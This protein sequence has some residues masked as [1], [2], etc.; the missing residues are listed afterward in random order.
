MTVTRLV[1]PIRITRPFEDDDWAAL[2]AAGRAGRGRPAG[3]GRAPD[4]GRRADLRLHRRLRGGRVEHRRL[5]P[6]QAASWPTQ[7]IAP[8][9]ATASAPGGLLHYGQGKWYPGEPL[10]RWALGLYWRA[11]RPAGL[12]RRRPGAGRA[13]P[14]PRRRRPTPTRLIA[15]AGRRG[16]ASTR[17]ASCRRARIPLHW[18]KAEG[19]LPAN[20]DARPTTRSTIAKGRDTLRAGHRRRLSK[21]VGY[22]LPL[23]RAGGAGRGPGWLSEAWR[24]ARP[25]LPGP[26]RLPGR[27]APAARAA[28]RSWSPRTIRTSRRSIPTSRAGRCRRSTTSWPRR[29]RA[30]AAGQARAQAARPDVRTA[31]TVEPR[32]G[33]LYVF[34]P[35]VARLE[36]YLELV[37]QVEAA[38]EGLPV[39]HRGLS[40]ARR[41]AAGRA[42]GHARPRRHRGQCP[43]GRQL[44]RGGRA[45]PPASTRTPAP[46]GWAPTSS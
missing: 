12:A 13:A 45:S 37:A 1:E 21:P 39:R 33:W 23:R 20:V 27:P 25:A 24:S 17:P 36:D 38:A 43:A 44:A 46:A 42:Q 5:G 40:A 3:A 22:V 10:P 19:D 4:H 18:I 16:W 7:L 35:P 29:R 30:H 2:D 15:A 26:G 32:D 9:A 6:D 8:A 28:C 31:L 14:E 34:M 11:R 41:S